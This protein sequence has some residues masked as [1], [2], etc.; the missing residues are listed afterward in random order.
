MFA[1]C[2]VQNPGCADQAV[3]SLETMV[4]N[5]NS[6]NHYIRRCL[7]GSIQFVYPCYSQS[8]MIL[9]GNLISKFRVLP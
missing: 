7:F 9:I 5:I 6:T 4:P 1:V 8:S 2:R 3:A